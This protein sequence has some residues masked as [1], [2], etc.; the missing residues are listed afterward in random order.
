MAR[1]S[2]QQLA[3]EIEAALARGFPDVEVVDVD[4]SPAAGAR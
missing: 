4:V 1:E 3:A 2:K